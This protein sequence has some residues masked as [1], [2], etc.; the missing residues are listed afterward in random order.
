MGLGTSGIGKDICN[1]GDGKVNIKN[2]DPFI[3]EPKVEN[4]G[5]LKATGHTVVAIVAP[6]VTVAVA[7]LVGG[8]TKNVAAGIAVGGLVGAVAGAIGSA[9]VCYN[10]FDATYPFLKYSLTLTISCVV[11]GAVTGGLVAYA[12]KCK[13]NMRVQETINERPQPPEE[14]IVEENPIFENNVNKNPE[15]TKNL[16]LKNFEGD[17]ITLEISKDAMDNLNSKNINMEMLSEGIEETLQNQLLT[18]DYVKTLEITEAYN[19]DGNII[20][21]GKI[22]MTSGDSLVWE[23]RLEIIDFTKDCSVKLTIKN[24]GENL[25]DNQQIVFE[26]KNNN[27]D[28]YELFKENANGEHNIKNIK[29]N[30]HIVSVE[31]QQHIKNSAFDEI[32]SILQDLENEHG[33]KIK[34]VK[35]YGKQR[36]FDTIEK[37]FFKAGYDYYGVSVTFEDDISS[38]MAISPNFHI[39]DCITQLDGSL[40]LTNTKILYGS[41]EL[42]ENEMKPTFGFEESNGGYSRKM[43]K[44]GEYGKYQ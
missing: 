32:S 3:D 36:I 12:T 5:C 19:V 16:N 34:S 41:P 38:K 23:C 44:V 8:L 28:L 37:E 25:I 21:T 17:E 9:V 14:I 42:I 13:S 31:T 35:I 33:T 6:L 11:A 22:K 10:T 27:F 39:S 24:I 20:L 1:A 15:Y 30:N 43:I 40:K 18:T 29:I 4:A 2:T 26:Q 7:G